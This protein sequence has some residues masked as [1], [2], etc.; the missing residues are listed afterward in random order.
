VSA[1]LAAALLSALFAFDCASTSRDVC[2]LLTPDDLVQIQGERP[3]ETKPSEQ[4]RFH[5]CF[6]RLPTFTSSVTIGV[7]Q[8]AREFWE[9]TFTE[10]GEGEE[11]EAAMREVSGI[12]D[13]AKWS[14]L[15]IGATLYVLRGET[16]LRVALGGKDPDA[17]RLEKATALA[18][19]ALRRL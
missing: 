16:M 1:G 7:A 9:Q 19:K 11:E 17:V 8:D 6:Y 12:G 14:A 15:P 13:E 3:V 2:A 5:Q 4:D 18:R 10:R